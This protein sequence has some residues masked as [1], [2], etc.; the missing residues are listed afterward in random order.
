MTHAYF[1]H[2]E[3]GQEPALFTHIASHEVGTKWWPKDSGLLAGVKEYITWLEQSAKISLQI[4]PEHCLDESE[5]CEIGMGNIFIST[6]S[7]FTSSS[8][9]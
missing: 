7:S 8:F 1:W 5:G 2:D 4:W 3:E 9:F 6:S